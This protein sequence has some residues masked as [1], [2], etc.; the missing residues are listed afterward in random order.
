MTVEEK[1]KYVAKPCPFCGHFPKVDKT[2]ELLVCETPDCAIS[3]WYIH[4]EEWNRRNG[5]L[6]N[7]VKETLV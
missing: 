5:T 1:E 6:H 4:M 3:G 2:T 7:G